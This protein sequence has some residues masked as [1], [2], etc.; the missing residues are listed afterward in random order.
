MYSGVDPEYLLKMVLQRQETIRDQA[1]KEAEVLRVSRLSCRAR[2]ATFK[3][4]RL[5]VMV[6]FEDVRGS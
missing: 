2:L 5:H 4:W 3:L 1:R 6:W